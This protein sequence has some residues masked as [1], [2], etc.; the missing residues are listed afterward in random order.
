MR[1][2]LMAALANIVFGLSHA[3]AE[4]PGLS[5]Q[6]E[7][8]IPADGLPLSAAVDKSFQKK[9]RVKV[10]PHDLKSDWVHGSPDNFRKVRLL[11][12][13]NTEKGFYKK[14]DISL[15]GSL[16]RVK[17]ADWGQSFAVKE[18][19]VHSEKPVKIHRENNPKK[20]HTYMGSLRVFVH[21]GKIHVVNTLPIEMYLRGVVPKESVSSWPLEALKAQ[22]VA[23]RTYAYYH[24]LTSSG[25]EFDVDDTA[26]FQVYAGIGEAKE[27]TDQAIKDTEGQVLTQNGEVIVAFF[28]AYSGGRTDSAKNIFGRQADY[29]LGAKEIFSRA[30]LKKELRP[31][32]QWIVEWTTDWMTPAGLMEKL[33]RA[34]NTFSDF[35]TARHYEIAEEDYNGKFNSVRTLLFEQNGLQTPLHFI[36]L[37]QYLGWSNFPAY[38][39]RL[40]KNGERVAFKG[41][42]WG[43]HVG[44]SQ[45]GAFMMAKHKNKNYEEILKHYYS[46]VDL[47]SF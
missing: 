1:L 44:M 32:S 17:P 14:L 26:R 9:I 3:M 5:F 27:S 40:L 30:E 15:E 28:H 18:I 33:K 2:I 13:L 41:H 43:H 21:K 12:E 39:F 37:R 19:L 6:H 24:L 36:K 45:W 22:A 46:N 47:S 11:G 4:L 35:S 42:G 20:S 29:C 10:F 34:S 25:K 8:S 23:A 31:S 7:S 16:L 38:H